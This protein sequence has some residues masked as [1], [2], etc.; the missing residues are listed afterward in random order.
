MVL[1]ILFLVIASFMVWASAAGAIEVVEAEWLKNNLENKNIIIVEVPEKAEPIA[2]EHKAGVMHIPGTVVA[3][4]YLDLGNTSVVPPTL[5]PSKEQFERLM[6]RLGIDEDTT[7]VAYDDKFGLFAS[8]L[9]VI[10]EYYGHDTNKL[11]LLNGGIV[12][13]KKLGYPLFDGHREVK[14]TSYKVEKANPILLTWSDIYRD[15]VRGGRHDVVLVDVRPADE[16]SAKKIR[17]I[18]GGHIPKAINVTGTDANDKQTHMFKS[19]DE[20]KKMFEAKGIKG[21]KAIYE[22][23]HSGDRSA[24]AYIILKYIIGYKDVK[25]YDGSWI[26]WSTILSL[27]AEG[28]VWYIEQK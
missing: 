10:M 21:D 9:L 6:S 2:G 12:N 25:V 18:R 27:P 22:Y 26:E 8:R 7:V 14:R 4:R 15:V 19:V 13:W 24:H 17:S 11:K 3:N 28:Q 1:K 16:Y 20:I 5:Y 23:C